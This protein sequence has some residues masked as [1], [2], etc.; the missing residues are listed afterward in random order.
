MRHTD[1][2]LFT[3]ARAAMAN[4]Y[5]PY[6]R[7]R[8]GACILTADDRTFCGCN[9]ENASYGL[10]ICAERGA[11]MAAVSGGAR[12]FVRIAIV[13]DGSLP[14]PCG[15][16]RQVLCEFSPEMEVLVQDG[17]GHTESAALSAL[18]PLSFGPHSL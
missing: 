13:S 2:E 4:A 15:A 14:W 17:E 8:V 18:L 1:S 7:Y 3:L 5:A 16:C 12:E 9:V 11:V 10:T 6:S